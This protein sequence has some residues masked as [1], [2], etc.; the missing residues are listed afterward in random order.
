MLSQDDMIVEQII[1][2]NKVTFVDTAENSHV[3]TDRSQ[4]VNSASFAM[5]SVQR[6]FPG[7]RSIRLPS[8]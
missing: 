4:S 3:D 5:S 2:D 8:H 6:D 1:T 7:L